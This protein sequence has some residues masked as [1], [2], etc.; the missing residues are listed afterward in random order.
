[1]ATNIQVSILVG[2]SS[3]LKVMQHCRNTLQEF[4]IECS[5][6]VLSAH[7]TPDLLMTHIKEAEANG[8][9]IFIASAGLAAHLAGTV[10]AHTLLPVIGVPLDA[11]GLGGMDA[12]LSTVQ[13]PGG[14]P[15][16][17][18]A[19]GKPGAVNAAYQAARILGIEDENIRTMLA[20]K[21]K[22]NRQMII[23]SNAQINELIDATNS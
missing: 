5:I 22:N 8:V 11:G 17:C 21:K 23:E 15:V 6:N 14:I 20:D 1:M 18:V 16:A 9:K 13:M 12:L 4:S 3:D 2:S 7:R 19:V 10:A